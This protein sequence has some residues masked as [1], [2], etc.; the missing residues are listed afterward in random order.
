LH[1][2]P[3]VPLNRGATTLALA[4]NFPLNSRWD[5][6][7]LRVCSQSRPEIYSVASNEKETEM[8]ATLEAKNTRYRIEGPVKLPGRLPDIDFIVEDI[9][10]SSVAIAELKWIRKPLRPLERIDR[11]A[12]VLHGI[13]QLT[14]IKQY[15]CEHP[16]YLVNQGRLAKS[17]SEYD[18]LQYL[19]I[20]RDHWVWVQ[21]RDGVA[22]M[23]FDAFLR[24][25]ND[26]TDLWSAVM[27]LLRYEWLPVEGR[28]FRVQV[29]RAI[30][31]GAAIESEVFYA[32]EGRAP[33]RV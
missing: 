24:S 11:D 3:F 18:H 30:A 19:L 20:A 7:I 23:D 27:E 13:D 8:R 16:K 2:Q 14:E 29:D 31:N 33:G 28:D 32:S 22:I 25:L 21:P 9:R 10:S 4:A 5:E 6:N 15:L 12:E 17:L 26:S 1:V